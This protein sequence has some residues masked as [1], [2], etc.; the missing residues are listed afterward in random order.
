MRGGKK[1]EHFI[2]FIHKSL[3]YLFFP[4]KWFLRDVAKADGQKAVSYSPASKQMAALP[5]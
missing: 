5:V 2:I 3:N 4:V 1:T